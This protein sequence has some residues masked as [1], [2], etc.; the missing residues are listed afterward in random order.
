MTGDA[1]ELCQQPVGVQDSFESLASVGEGF[2]PPANSLQ[3]G[4]E[5]F[6][7]DR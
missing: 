3:Y 6:P 1:E 5:P 2:F 7:F 4:N